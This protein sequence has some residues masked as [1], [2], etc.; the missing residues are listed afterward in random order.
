MVAGHI[1][2]YSAAV[3]LTIVQLLLKRGSS[4]VYLRSERA[5]VLLPYLNALLLVAGMW[6]SQ[7][8]SLYLDAAEHLLGLAPRSCFH[9]CFTMFDKVEIKKL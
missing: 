7:V 1:A 4:L 5:Y 3:A 8:V 2:R 9:D 6:I